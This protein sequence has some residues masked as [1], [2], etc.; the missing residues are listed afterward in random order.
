MRGGCCKE[1]KR[2]GKG[3]AVSAMRRND[4][5]RAASVPVK[6]QR[7]SREMILSYGC[8]PVQARVSL[9]QAGLLVGTVLG[10]EALP[11]PGLLGGCDYLFLGAGRDH[12]DL[13]NR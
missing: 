10:S 4:F 5:S 13:F 7:G 9:R 6:L 11:R 3:M 2:R 1:P 8:L 12:K